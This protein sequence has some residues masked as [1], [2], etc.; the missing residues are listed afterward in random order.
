[1]EGFMGAQWAMYGYGANNPLGFKDLTGLDIVPANFA[2]SWWLTKLE[3]DR[4]IGFFIREMAEDPNWH[5]DFDV[6]ADISSS[7][8]T[9][10]SKGMPP[11]YWKS[12]VNRDV[13]NGVDPEGLRKSTWFTGAHELGHMYSAYHAWRSGRETTLRESNEMAVIFDN[14]ARNLGPQRRYH[15]GRDP[16]GNPTPD[17]P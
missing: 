15:W 10:H 5:G 14:F 3:R 7:G 2:S 1:M 16:S 11:N 13:C 8:Q 4:D 17:W 6:L 9:F 12:R